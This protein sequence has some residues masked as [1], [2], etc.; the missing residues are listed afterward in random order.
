MR[1]T[2]YEILDFL[3]DAGCYV[4]GV[5]YLSMGRELHLKHR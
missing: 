4:A 3:P 1:F 2:L 5:G